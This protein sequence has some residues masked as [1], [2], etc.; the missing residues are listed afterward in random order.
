DSFVSK[1]ADL[2]RTHQQQLEQAVAAARASG[3]SDAA[4]R[5]GP[6]AGAA[7]SQPELFAQYHDGF[8][9]QTRGWPKQPVD[10]AIAWLRAKKSEVKAVAD[11]GC[12]DAKIAASVPQPSVPYPTT[13]PS[14]LHLN[15]SAMGTARRLILL[16]LVG[17]LCVAKADFGEAIVGEAVDLNAAQD[18]VDGEEARSMESLL[19][20]AIANS[21]PDKLAAQAEA[22]VRQEVVRDLKEQR[23]RVKE[24]LD[25][26]RAQPTETDML[27][28]GIAILRRPGASDA[29]LLAA[30]QA[31][32]VLVEP[33]DNANDLR[34]LGG[35]GPVV[36]QLVRGPQLAAAAAH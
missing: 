34:P 8:Q 29:E 36:A 24:L 10:L 21:D 14:R 35:L 32:Q 11:F 19:H 1:I 5:T 17:V 13:W 2:R 9:S 22:H 25:H 16:A 18:A 23:Q 31:L 7:A 15:F 30:L 4:G 33:I 3:A 12:G 26:V 27:K 6:R 20:W 28:E